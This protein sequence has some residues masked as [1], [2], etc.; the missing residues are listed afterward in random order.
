MN[1]FDLHIPVIL[2]PTASGKTSLAVS[3]AKEIGGEIISIDSRQVYRGMDIGTGKDLHEYGDI[4]YHLI[5]IL[6][7]G[8]KYNVAL[9]V[10]DAQKAIFNCLERGKTPILCGGTGLYLQALV[11]QFQRIF[12]P[13]D[14]ASVEAF[15]PLEKKKLIDKIEDLNPYFEV[16]KQSRKRLLRSLEILQADSKPQFDYANFK[17]ELFGLDP[18]LEIRRERIAKRLLARLENGALVEE[19]KGLL[20]KGV[21]HETLQ[22][23]GLEY[24]YVSS[25]II[26]EMQFAEMQAKL[27]TEIHRFAKRQMTFLRS[28]ESKGISIRWIPYKYSLEDKLAFILGA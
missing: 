10:Q 9:F 5:D 21:R 8:E 4:P 17:F 28:M 27:L 15:V 20:S 11:Q 26:E 14:E 7:A 25:Y 12:I 2:G 3:L 1:Y 23:Y 13:R 18:P 22:Y 24:R 19:V 6:D 16:D